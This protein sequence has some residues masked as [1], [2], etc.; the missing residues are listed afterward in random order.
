MTYQISEQQVQKLIEI[1]KMLNLLEVHGASNVSALYTSMVYM[2]DFLNELQK[3]SEG[4]VVDQTKG[5]K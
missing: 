4:I 1:N 3:Q 5:G 2:Q